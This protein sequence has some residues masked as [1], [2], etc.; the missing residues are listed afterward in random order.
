MMQMKTTDDMGKLNTLLAIVT[1][2]LSFDHS[3]DKRMLKQYG[4][5]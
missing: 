5:L 2:I 4:W 3:F 1:E